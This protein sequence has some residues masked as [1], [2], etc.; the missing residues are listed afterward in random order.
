MR[1]FWPTVE[2]LV[3]LPPWSPPLGLRLDARWFPCL[4]AFPQGVLAIDSDRLDL[5]AGLARGVVFQQGPGEPELCVFAFE[6]GCVEADL[7]IVGSRPV[8]LLF[9]DSVR[10]GGGIDARCAGARRSGPGL[11]AAPGGGGGFGGPGGAPGGAGAGGPS[12]GLRGACEIGSGGQPGNSSGG[13]G[14]GGLQLGAV[15]RLELVGAWIDVSGGAGASARQ[16]TAGGG[17]SG[18]SLVLHGREVRLD[19]A[20]ALS[21]R[22]GGGGAAAG[23]GVRGGG[24]GGGGYVLGLTEL[25]RRFDPR[26]AS[27]LTTG[28]RGG[29]AGRGNS[30][31][32]GARGVV[33]LAGKRDRRPILSRDE[34]R[35]D[36]QPGFRPR[37]PL[38]AS[39]SGETMSRDSDHPARTRSTR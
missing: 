17:G 23:P 37:T 8:A 2:M 19:G 6:G 3:E 34:P 25:G 31:K 10:L 38:I 7:T 28:G 20:T 13:L 18:G 22:G 35:A 26:G 33:F 27:F 11:A 32:D 12:Y 24:G 36:E 39:S 21:V 5:G 15:G 14:G 29:R 9:R 16:G 30:G 4:G 1:L